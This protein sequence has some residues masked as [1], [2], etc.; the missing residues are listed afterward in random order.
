MN[1]HRESKLAREHGRSSIGID[2]LM[3][4]IMGNLSSNVTPVL[5]SQV[6]DKWLVKVRGSEKDGTHHSPA[7]C[8]TSLSTDFHNLRVTSNQSTLDSMKK[9]S[10]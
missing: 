6:Q 3:Q 2:L 4:T 7:K 10:S 5:C 9:S 8:K 1:Q